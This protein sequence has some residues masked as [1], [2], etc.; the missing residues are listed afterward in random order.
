MP[1]FPINI[2]F[3]S[4]TSFTLL[5]KFFDSNQRDDIL[6]MISAINNMKMKEGLEQV[7]F[8]IFS[9]IHSQ[10]PQKSTERL[11]SFRTSINNFCS[12]SHCQPVRCK[13]PQKDHGIDVFP[14]LQLSFFITYFCFSRIKISSNSLLTVECRLLNL[15]LLFS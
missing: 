4:K 12:T 11:F 13:L 10:F 1:K 2:G 7:K 8:S 15:L 5:R 9:G 6:H 14:K 3:S